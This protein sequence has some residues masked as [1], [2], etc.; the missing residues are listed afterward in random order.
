MD[1]VEI[2]GETAD[3][4]VVCSL[5]DAIRSIKDSI[6]ELKKDLQKNKKDEYAKQELMECMLYLD[7]LERTYEYYGGNIK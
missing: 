5:K 6:K 7:A 3:R 2:D 1:K 4:I